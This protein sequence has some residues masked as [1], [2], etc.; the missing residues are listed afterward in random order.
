M[1][2]TTHKVNSIWETSAPADTKRVYQNQLD[3]FYSYSENIKDLEALIKYPSEKLQKELE[4]YCDFLNKR[5][6]RGELSPNSVGQ[7]FS[8]IKNAL[9][10]NYRE[11]DIKWKPIKN[12]WPAKER[13][14]GYKPYSNKDLQTMLLQAK[15]ARNRAVI[16]FQNSVGG[17]I[18]I[19]DH[20]LLMKHTIKMS[21]TGDD[22]MDCKFA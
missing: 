2:E 18:G 11:N 5:V 9:E 15:T 21:S 19:H 20:P 13:L 10:N 4:G 12:K 7:K 8:G 6:E 3:L 17:R 16:A 1:S 22:N 14:S